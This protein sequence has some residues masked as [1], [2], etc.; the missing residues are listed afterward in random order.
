MDENRPKNADKPP[1]R[2]HDKY[3]PY[4]IYTVGIKTDAPRYYVTFTDD[5]RVQHCLEIDREL[6]DA[7]DGFELED[8]SFLNAVDNHYEHSE[9][10]EASLNRRAFKPHEAVD[11][12]VIRQ[13]EGEN[14]HEALKKLPEIQQR[15]L[16]LYY[17]EGLTYQQIAEMEG[18]KRQTVQES[19]A[20]ALKRLNI[21]LP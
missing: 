5:Q 1:K 11:D 2:R 13:L 10:T 19:V 12:F 3:N 14:L 20:A 9:L 6:F 8:L 4:R 18:C 16:T 15:R 7:F 17:F 21:I